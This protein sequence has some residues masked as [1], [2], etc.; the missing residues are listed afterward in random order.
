MATP[1]RL[2][3][4]NPNSTAA[5]VIPVGTKAR[6]MTPD[7][8]ASIEVEYC[9][10][11][12][13]VRQQVG[14]GGRGICVIGMA[15]IA[16]LNGASELLSVEIREGWH[17]C[18]SHHWDGFKRRGGGTRLPSQDGSWDRA[19]FVRKRFPKWR[20][21]AVWCLRPRDNRYTPVCYFAGYGASYCRL[22]YHTRHMYHREVSPLARNNR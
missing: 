10:C 22:G 3:Y 16:V 15:E 5:C 4:V 2:P 6:T 9:R 20:K 11:W 12:H 1:T 17:T 14:S 7:I 21:P 13:G 8:S 18:V 19:S